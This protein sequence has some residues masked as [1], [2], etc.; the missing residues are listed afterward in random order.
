MQLEEVR[1]IFTTAEIEISGNLDIVPVQFL[2]AIERA[3]RKMQVCQVGCHWFSN[4]C[5]N[6]KI[7]TLLKL[8]LVTFQSVFVLD[9]ISFVMRKPFFGV[10]EKG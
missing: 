10:S 2:K 9:Q 7:S 5:K 3:H 8:L 1:S 6:C 4:Y